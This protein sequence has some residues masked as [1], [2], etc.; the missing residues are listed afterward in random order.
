MSGNGVLRGGMTDAADALLAVVVGVGVVIADVVA[1]G[2]AAVTVGG[3]GTAM[4]AL[5][6]AGVRA[7][8]GRGVPTTLRRDVG[9]LNK[10][11]AGMML[12]MIKMSFRRV[13]LWPH[14]VVVS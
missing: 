8:I 2:V 13:R 11:A 5:I 1:A 7:T 6:C 14:A 10:R 3:A 9:A 4:A 12:P